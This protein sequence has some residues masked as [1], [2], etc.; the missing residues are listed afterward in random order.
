MFGN[1]GDL[2][3]AL[4]ESLKPVSPTSVDK[5]SRASSLSILQCSYSDVV[6]GPHSFS[7]REYSHLLGRKNERPELSYCVYPVV[8][9][10]LM[11][12]GVIPYD[13]FHKILDILWLAERGVPNSECPQHSRFD[14]M[15][16]LAIHSSHKTHT[17]EKTCTGITAYLKNFS[18]RIKERSSGTMISYLTMQS[19]PLLGLDISTP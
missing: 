7:E 18:V 14:A 11:I 8:G 6:W 3:S 1:N 2:F 13:H 12:V 5:S 4:S 17:L 15:T 16:T 19:G 9:L 10:E